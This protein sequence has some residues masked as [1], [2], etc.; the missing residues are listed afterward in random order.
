[1]RQRKVLVCEDHTIVA[2]GLKSIIENSK[3]F[4]LCGHARTQ[5]EG[6]QLLQSQEPDILLLDLNLQ[7]ADGFG[8][9]EKAKQK[10]TLLILILTM[11]RDEF[12]I[13]RAQKEGAHGYLEKT[14]SN[15]ELLLAMART[16][17]DEFFLSRSL[18]EEA[19]SRQKFRDQFANRM[20]LTNR[21]MELI[22]LFADG[23][24]AQEIADFLSLSYFTVET[25]RKNIF[26]KLQINNVVELVKFMHENK[27][28]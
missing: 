4:V 2:D 26:K 28:V 22:P 5:Q 15:A 23:R 25:H 27:L 3:D 11:Y 6:I 18:R 14:V 1:M 7:G 21:E 12:L 24:T 19:A 20:K 17:A 10:P 9:L 13:A 16:P 8:I